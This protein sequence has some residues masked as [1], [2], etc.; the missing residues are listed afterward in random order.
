MNGRS[1]AIAVRSSERKI[2][3]QY[4]V[5]RG[6]RFE[7][8]VVDGKHSRTFGA[9]TRVEVDPDRHAFDL[10]Y[11]RGKLGKLLVERAVVVAFGQNVYA[12]AE[13][14]HSRAFYGLLE[15][16]KLVVEKRQKGNVQLDFG[17]AVEVPLVFRRKIGAEPPE[18]GYVGEKRHHTAKHGAYSRIFTEIAECLLTVFQRFGIVGEEIPYVAGL[19]IDQKIKLERRDTL[20]RQRVRG[21]KTGLVRK[22]GFRIY[23]TDIEAERL[24]S[25][26]FSFLRGEFLLSLR[27]LSER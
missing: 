20:T 26:R 19:E 27:G 11:P 25:I 13:F 3:P 15:R 6:T 4:P 8:F 22:H 16:Q 21:D 9:Q 1:L 14:R 23:Q 2:E 24:F 10:P 12:L 5:E 17:D 7:R 18:L